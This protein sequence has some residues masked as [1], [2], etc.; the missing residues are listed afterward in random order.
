MTAEGWS[1]GSTVE[2]S[3]EAEP[4]REGSSRGELSSLDELFVAGAERVDELAVEAA[5]WLAKPGS[6]PAA[7]WM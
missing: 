7:S 1:V 2:E 5:G 3:P 4:S 6:R